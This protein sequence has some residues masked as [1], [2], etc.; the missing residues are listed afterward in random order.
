[1]EEQQQYNIITYFYNKIYQS[2]EE[3]RDNLYEEVEISCRKLY[4]CEYNLFKIITFIIEK[5]ID[6]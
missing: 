4:N 2:K 6:C 1:M 3:D 5:G